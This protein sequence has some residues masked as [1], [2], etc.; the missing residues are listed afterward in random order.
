[1]QL[2]PF[3]SV[4]CV[5]CFHCELIDSIPLDSNDS[6]L[7]LFPFPFP[8]QFPLFPLFLIFIIFP[9]IFIVSFIF[10]GAHKNLFVHKHIYLAK[11]TRTTHGWGSMGR[12]GASRLFAR[13]MGGRREKGRGRGRRGFW[14]FGCTIGRRLI[15]G[16]SWVIAMLE[17]FLSGPGWN[18]VNCR[19]IRW[20]V[21]F[22]LR[23]YLV[24]VHEGCFAFWKWNH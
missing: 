13:G 3:T 10:V 19:D 16:L 8:F 17:L 20:N 2:K 5:H 4:H 14:R 11:R 7:F 23:R 12:E 21:V 15:T 9:F 24:F 18:F 22:L 1:M 6:S